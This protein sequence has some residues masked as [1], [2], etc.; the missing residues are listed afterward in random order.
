M[1]DQFRMLVLERSYSQGIGTTTT[2]L[3]DRHATAA[4]LLNVPVCCDGNYT[5]AYW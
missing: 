2:R 1:L 4:T 5:P 3:P